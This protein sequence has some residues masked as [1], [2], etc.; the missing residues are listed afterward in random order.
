VAFLQAADQTQVH[1]RR[2]A[3]QLGEERHAAGREVAQGHRQPLESEIRLE[4]A[5]LQVEID[6]DHAAAGAGHL[7]SEIRGEER[8]S[9]APL[10]TRERPDGLARRRRL[11]RPR[12][13]RSPGRPGSLPAAGCLH[14]ATL[15]WRSFSSN[16]SPLKEMRRVFSSTVVSRLTGRP[17]ILWTLRSVSRA[18]LCLSSIPS[19]LCLRSN[20]PLFRKLPSTT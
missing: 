2:L 19:Y 17:Q 16:S 12:R 3:R 13:R 1:R 7:H 9:D 10:A 6:E 8:S 11:R 15:S 4:V 14:Q 18:S 20:S 5:P